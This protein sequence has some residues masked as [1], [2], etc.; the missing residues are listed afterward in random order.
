MIQYVYFYVWLFPLPVFCIIVIFIVVGWN[1][2]S[3]S[4]CLHETIYRYIYTHHSLFICSWRTFGTIMNNITPDFLLYVFYCMGAHILLSKYLG[5][6]MLSE[7]I[8]ES[9]V[10]VSNVSF[11]NC[12]L[13]INTFISSVRVSMDSHPY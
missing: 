9:S 5:V 2:E 12:L 13:L 4:K 8:C 6:D 11:I 10:L 7:M 1:G 3:L